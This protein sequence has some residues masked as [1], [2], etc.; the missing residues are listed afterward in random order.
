MVTSA[1]LPAA[2]EPLNLRTHL[3][4]SATLVRVQ[5]WLEDWVCYG[6]ASSAAD[7]WMLVDVKW[8]ECSA[9]PAVHCLVPVDE[10]S[11]LVDRV[12]KRNI[13]HCCCCCC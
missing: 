12:G 10:Q 5:G 4:L 6:V 3:W 1:L 2:M 9:L 7:G 13:M 8:C 11:R